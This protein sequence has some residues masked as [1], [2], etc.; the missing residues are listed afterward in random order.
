[1]H[2][3]HLL[4]VETT[5]HQIHLYKLVAL[6]EK[7]MSFYHSLAKGLTNYCNILFSLMAVVLGFLTDKKKNNNYNY[8]ALCV[9][10]GGGS[11]GGGGR[12]VCFTF[13]PNDLFDC[14]FVFK[15]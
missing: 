11:G 9:G 10:E 4:P 14:L 13:L 7:S 3:H 5:P 8:K 1:M 12:C 15:R 2:P 6:H